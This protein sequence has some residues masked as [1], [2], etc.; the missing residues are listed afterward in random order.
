MNDDDKDNTKNTS[1]R[2]TQIGHQPIDSVSSRAMSFKHKSN[3]QKKQRES[4]I[5]SKS[6][7]NM[8]NLDKII[9]PPL[10]SDSDDYSSSSLPSSKNTK[11]DLELSFSSS[12]LNM[13]YQSSLENFLSNDN[14][15]RTGR[16]RRNSFN[17][18]CEESLNENP[19]E[20]CDNERILAI[21]ARAVPKPRTAIKSISFK[22]NKLI[23]N[24][25]LKEKKIKYKKL[26][27]RKV[28]RKKIRTVLKNRRSIPIQG[29]NKIIGPPLSQQ[30][31][32]F[33]AF[34]IDSF[35]DKNS[36]YRT[37][38]QYS[39]LEYAKKSFRLHHRGS[40]LQHKFIP[41]ED[42][43]SF[44]FKPIHKPLLKS[45]P[46]N[47]KKEAIFLFDMILQ[48][49][50]IKS[51]TD[52]FT[53]VE[54]GIQII[55]KNLCLIDEMYYQLVKQTTN[56][57]NIE[58][59][60]KTWKL[61]LIIASTFPVSPEHRLRILAHIA[62]NLYFEETSVSNYCLNVYITFESSFYKGRINNNITKEFI[63]KIS[64]EIYIKPSLFD[65][66]LYEILLYQRSS[67]PN[68]PIPYIEYFLI[69]SLLS[70]RSLNE[71]D[72]FI[73]SGKQSV[74]DEIIQENAP[75]D[76][77]SKCDVYELASLLLYWVKSLSNSLIPASLLD[78]FHRYC[79][80]EKYIEFTTKLPQAHCLSL[81]YLTGF[82]HEFSQGNG[83]SPQFFSSLFG[84]P[85]IQVVRKFRS[86][87]SA[88]SF[89]NDAIA[90]L[91]HLIQNWDTSPI[92][93]LNPE[94][95]L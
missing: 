74:I 47:L 94:L 4:I 55:K 25:E 40:S 39:I 56:N 1:K 31:I 95:L 60:L 42:L 68:L 54:K 19:N 83:L 17:I 6:Y 43:I 50:G 90:F 33:D 44:S 26:K 20:T 15:L 58:R 35:V 51:C 66:T 72:I 62:R 2:H 5:L 89:E 16:K 23:D 46:N 48:F 93:P 57:N 84:P 21:T 12:N 85:I 61:F 70:K 32:L 10:E 80:E 36:L 77:I 52:P 34:H 78:E 73:K 82:L 18:E 86:P 28:K 24:P 59:L 88:Q 92:Y 14:L 63:E 41:V 22:D 45:I 49:T 38:K 65:S 7:V 29:Q 9:P 53:L 71:D 75:I 37:L 76:K 87:Y 79:S 64:N 81:M 30:E 3:N 67:Y 8:S 27:Y 91:Y 11:G 13:M 69:Q